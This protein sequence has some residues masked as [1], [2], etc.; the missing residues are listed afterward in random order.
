M[1]RIERA[2]SDH[3]YR[4]ARRLFEEYAA[5]LD[6]T[7][8]FQQFDQELADLRRDYDPPTGCLLLAQEGADVVGC[9]GL[10]KFAED[11]C[12]MKRLYVVQDYRGHGLGRILAERVIQEAKRLG[13]ARMRL[14]TVTAME[15]ANALYASLG[16]RPIEPYRHNPLEDA[17][18][19]ELSLDR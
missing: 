19:F 16:F 12:E 10:R 1:P 2:Q 5:S 9:V 17:L 7:L 11:I 18:F 8:D 13:Y 6:F 14:D 4:Q 15:A 3:Q